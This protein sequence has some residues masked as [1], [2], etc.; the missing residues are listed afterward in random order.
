MPSQG[1]LVKM[2]SPGFSVSGGKRFNIWRSVMGALPM[3]TGT[4][5]VPWAMELASASSTTQVRS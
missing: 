5:N 1:S 2:T 4:L 3:N